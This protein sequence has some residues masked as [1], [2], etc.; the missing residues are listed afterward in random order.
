LQLLLGGLEEEKLCLGQE[1][2]G[3]EGPSVGAPPTLTHDRFAGPAASN[4][5][6]MFDI[7]TVAPHPERG[8]TAKT[9]AHWRHLYR[10][11]NA[12]FDP[13]GA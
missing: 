9:V 5:T 4:R 13:A 11:G 3:R 6:L 7:S 8:N 1:E 2:S 10:A 12:L